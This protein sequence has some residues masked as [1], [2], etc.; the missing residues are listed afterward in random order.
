MK[1]CNLKSQQSVY[2]LIVKLLTF[3]ETNEQVSANSIS[4]PNLATM[5]KD[6]GVDLQQI[7]Q[8]DITPISI[9]SLDTDAVFFEVS[10]FC[11]VIAE[12]IGD[13]ITSD[14][15]SRNKDL[16]NAMLGIIDASDFKS[17]LK[18]VNKTDAL[19]E[20]EFLTEWCDVINVILEDVVD[21][22]DVSD[23]TEETETEDA[24][25][26]DPDGNVLPGEDGEEEEDNDEETDETTT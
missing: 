7:G 16:M 26:L 6:I 22:D 25:V 11:R 20:K 14:I 13:Y 3:D 19:T 24:E 23:F 8:T 10:N 5:L 4:S 2:N 15:V 18:G 1:L 21:N 17:K 12:Y 9:S